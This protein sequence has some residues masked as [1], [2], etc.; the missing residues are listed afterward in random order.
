MEKV[1]KGPLMLVIVP[2]VNA[3]QRKDKFIYIYFICIY[4]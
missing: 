1:N 4:I 3:I 2:H